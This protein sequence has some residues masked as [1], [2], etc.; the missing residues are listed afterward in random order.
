MAYEI[1]EQCSI[2]KKDE[3]LNEDGWIATSNY[4]Q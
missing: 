1:V 3:N 2:G 4:V